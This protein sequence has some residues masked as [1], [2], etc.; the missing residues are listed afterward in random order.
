[1]IWDKEGL[2]NKIYYHVKSVVEH[3]KKLYFKNIVKSV[4]KMFKIRKKEKQKEKEMKE[5]NNMSLVVMSQIKR[6]TM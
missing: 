3:L 1:M 6:K 2:Y 5:I 4:K